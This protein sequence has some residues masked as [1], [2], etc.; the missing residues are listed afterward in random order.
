MNTCKGPRVQVHQVREQVREMFHLIYNSSCDSHAVEDGNINNCRHSSIVDGL[1]AVGPHVGTLSQ[2]YV[3]GAQAETENRVDQVKKKKK[4]EKNCK[5]ATPVCRKEHSR[6]VLGKR[7][8]A[9]C[10][11]L[12]R[13]HLALGCSC[14]DEASMPAC[15][16]ICIHTASWVGNTSFL[17]PSSC[18]PVGPCQVGGRAD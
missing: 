6:P 8:P 2:I 14:T 9:G 4:K 17:L 11:Q 10:P 7:A 15:R 3:A 1:G 18:S 16:G 13:G 5:E 12:A